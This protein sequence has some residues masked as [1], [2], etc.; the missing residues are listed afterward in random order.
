M[1]GL[2]ESDEE[3][4]EV[5]RDLRRAGVDL[6]T[7]GQYLRPSD[8]ELPVER[9]VTPEAFAALAARG[10]ELGFRDVYAGPFVRSSY[11]A[12]ALYAALR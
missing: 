7:I 2:G 5:L 11:N 3:I 4:V 8:R 9:Y 10:R 6:A 1:V 12:D